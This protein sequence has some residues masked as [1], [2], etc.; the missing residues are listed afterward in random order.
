MPVKRQ[1]FKQGKF[2]KKLIVSCLLLV[3]VFCAWLIYKPRGISLRAEEFVTPTRKPSLQKM[4]WAFP[5]DSRNVL[6][7]SDRMILYSIE[8]MQSGEKGFHGYPIV[9]Q[10][11]IKSRK[12]KSDLVAHFYDGMEDEIFAA[13]CFQPHHAIRA[14]KGKKVVDMVI[15]FG[16]SG[17]EITYGALEGRTHVSSTPQKFYDAVLTEAGVPLRKD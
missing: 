13:G 14:I 10:T 6:E 5:K 4:K 2:M 3:T 8:S 12:I 7:N 17:V 15:C 16:C 1:V 11:E 9:G